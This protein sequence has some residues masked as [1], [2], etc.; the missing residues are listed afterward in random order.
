[1]GRKSSAESVWRNRLAKYSKSSLS[2]TEFC[3]QQGVSVPSFYQWR[4]RLCGSCSAAPAKPK[5]SS[6]AKKASFV[7]LG[8]SPAALVEI[9]FP[10]GV[11]VRVPASNLEALQQVITAANAICR[12]AGRC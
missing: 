6:H 3:R 10:S 12:E 11:R 1:M 8:V 2:V 4:K 7:P 9:E 5:K